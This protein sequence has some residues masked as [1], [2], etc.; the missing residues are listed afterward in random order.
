MRLK[1]DDTETTFVL[2]N[3]FLYWRENIVQTTDPTIRVRGQIPS[4]EQLN[5][6]FSTRLFS[7]GK[8]TLDGLQR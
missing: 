2:T 8:C 3:N 1:N 7:A 5:R 4:V 6:D